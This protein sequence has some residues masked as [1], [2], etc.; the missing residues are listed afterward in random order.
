MKKENL[1]ILV[2]GGTGFFGRALTLKLLDKGYNVR[3][4][5]RSRSQIKH[6]NITIFQGDITNSGDLIKAVKGCSAIFHCA[7]EKDDVDQMALLNT[8]VTK[9][10]FGIAK[11]YQV[12]FFCHLSSVGVIGKTSIKT[13]DE[14]SS[15]KPMNYYEVTKLA[16]ENIV[17][18]GLDDGSVIILRPTNI[19]DEKYIA[20][21]IQKTWKSN[22]RDFLKGR[23]NAHFVYIEDVVAAAIYLFE[24][25]KENTVETYIVSCDESKGNTFN[26]VRLHLS[27]ISDHVCDPF[28]ISAPLCVPYLARLIKNKRTNWGDVVYSSKKLLATGFCYPYGLQ[29][30]LTDAQKL[31]PKL[32]SK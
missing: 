4:I 14:L 17:K 25:V 32:Y 9:I 3:V 23:E 8:E 5:T 30:G 7:A 16:S 31:L 18:E 15:C 19:F 28:I 6:P 2:T 10:L 22:V 1:N 11:R 24:K 21:L 13:V 26:E 27:S 29:A 20:L 12:K